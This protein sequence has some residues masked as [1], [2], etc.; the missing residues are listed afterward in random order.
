MKLSCE[1]CGSISGE[2]WRNELRRIAFV[3]LALAIL[4]V[5]CKPSGKS[6]PA[7]T[8]KD[9]TSVAIKPGDVCP[10]LDTNRLAAASKGGRDDAKPE[11][12]A[13]SADSVKKPVT[14]PV[15]RETSAAKTEVSATPPKSGALPRLWDFGSDNCIPCKMMMPI[16]DTLAREYAGK[17]DVRI[18]NVYKEQAL[19]SQHRIQIIPTQV[20]ID[21]TGKELYRHVGFFPRDSILMRFKQFGFEK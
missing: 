14:P 4:T 20:F 8:R 5:A 11:K 9:T 12:P 19:A 2:K 16:L 21:P 15:K 13:S 17:V 7:S 3:G 10:P 6:V 18:I 1:I